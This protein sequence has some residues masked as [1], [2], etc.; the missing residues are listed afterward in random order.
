MTEV[1]NKGEVELQP[2]SDEKTMATLIH[3]LGI[4]FGVFSTLI[5]WLIQKDKSKYV[6][7][8]GKQNMNW[9]LTLIIGYFASF[10]L[11]FVLIGFLTI[12]AIGVLDLV[13]SIL[14]AVAANKGE[15][16]KFPVAIPFIR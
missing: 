10:I 11:M 6:D 1:E 16:Y 9:Q 4:F 12:I 3:V 13:F 5:I 7:H 8:H 14:A 2:T 15:R